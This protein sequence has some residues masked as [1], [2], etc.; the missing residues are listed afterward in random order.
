[1]AALP[2]AQAAVSLAAPLREERV[3][4]E[5]RVFPT[6]AAGAQAVGGGGGGREWG[7][8]AERASLCI[9]R[10]TR[11]AAAGLAVA[12]LPWSPPPL[13]APLSFLAPPASLSGRTRKAC[14]SSMRRP[15]ATCASVC[16][17]VAACVASRRR[18]WDSASVCHAT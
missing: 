6:E 4:R 2:Q 1:V 5:V 11:G 8:N 17:T 9:G 15:C 16:A 13:L 18:V 3:E 14:M 12:I 7:A 10:W